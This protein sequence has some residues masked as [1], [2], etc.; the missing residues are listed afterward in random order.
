MGSLVGQKKQHRY[1]AKNEQRICSAFVFRGT[2]A[3]VFCSTI[4][5]VGACDITKRNFT[6]RETARY[7]NFVA[8]RRTL[9][10]PVPHL[11]R[12][13]RSTTCGTTPHELFTSTTSLRY[14]ATAH[15]AR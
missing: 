6:L 10:Q 1:S 11:L 12:I 15:T 2:H 13:G 4:N 7:F 8:V 14:G 3:A 9:R 5:F